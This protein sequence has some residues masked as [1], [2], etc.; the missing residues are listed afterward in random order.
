MIPALLVLALGT[1]AMKAVGPVLAAGRELPPALE[2]LTTL[3]PAALL[4]ALV[5]TQTVSGPGGLTIDA[6][7]LGVGAAGI[8]VACRAPFGVVVLIGAAVTAAVRAIGWA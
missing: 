7:L 8:A 5:A 2:R 3:L 1:F 6:R 4:A